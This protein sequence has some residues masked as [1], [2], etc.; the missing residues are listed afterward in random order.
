[1]KTGRKNSL[2][3]AMCL[4]IHYGVK[5]SDIYD[6]SCIIQVSWIPPMKAVLECRL[7]FKA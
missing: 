3:S 5:G 4:H 2:L 7:K 6:A 1:M